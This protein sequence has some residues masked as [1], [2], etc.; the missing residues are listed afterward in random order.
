M[1]IVFR[2][3][4][5]II[6]GSGH[7]IRCLTLAKELKNNGANIIFICRGHEGNLNKLISNKAF[8]V[9][10]LPEPENMECSFNKKEGDNYEEWI[11]VSQKED[12]E[13]TIKYLGTDQPDWIIVDHYGLD[14]V[15][16]KTL[17]P[18]VGKVMVIDDLANR[19]HDCDLLLDHN[20]FEDKNSRYIKLVPAGCTQLLGPEYV[21]LRPEFAE[22]RNKLKLR[23][24][25]LKRIYVFF[26][27]SDPYNLTGMTLRALSEPK[28]SHLVVD[29]VIGENNPHRDELKKL[30]L[31]RPHTHLHI[32]VDNMA[33]IMGQ[34]DLAV[35]SGGMN[36]W[37]RICLGLPS[38]VIGF[39]TNHKVQLNDLDKNGYINYLGDF[40]SVTQ[41]SIARQIHK[42][43]NDFSDY[44]NQI[45]YLYKIVDSNGVKKTR[46]WVNGNLLK[47]NWDVKSA[48]YNDAALY[49]DWAN[50]KEVR[51]NAINKKPISWEEHL[52]WFNKKIK[53]KNSLLYLIF[54]NDRPIGQ[55]RFDD[56]GDFSR[57]DYSIS[58]QYRSRKLGK[59]LLD[60]AIK[61]F[62]KN[63]NQKILGEVLSSNIASAKTF[64]SL[65]FSME[66]NRGNKIYIKEMKNIA[67]V[68]A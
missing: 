30:V 21:L 43:I 65:G 13:E 29:V 63:S 23:N 31:T 45:D 18:H 51:K 50:D 8:Q 44:N 14:E 39:A 19:R 28:L 24:G 61:E 54:C 22:A 37:E 52:T 32:Q 36:T 5:S 33:S 9:I 17:R 15:W 20:W 4:S 27:G 34:A 35:G 26:G 25:V 56:E 53:D 1:N 10:E 68:N 6:M 62:R 57:I 38:V 48:T 67:E 16:E 12:A 64:E 58:R 47:Q 11:G 66:I 40:K 59:R 49:W 60:L 2:T 55:V 46:L 7:V 42:M 41:S 3:D